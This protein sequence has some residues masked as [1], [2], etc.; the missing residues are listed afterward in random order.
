MP[1]DKALR[2]EWVN[3][4]YKSGMGSVQV[5]PPP[6]KDF[7]RV[8]H[9]TSAEFAISDIGL[10]R[11]KVARF[12]DVND[13]FELMALTFMERRMRNIARKFKHTYDSHTG[14]LCFSADW[15]NPVLWS[16]YG[17]KHR[18]ICLGFNLARSRAEKVQYEDNIILPKLG[19]GGTTESLDE[20]QQRLLLH[21]KFRHWEYEEEIRSF[22]ELETMV[23]EGELYFCPF[24][25]NLQLTEVILGPEC[26]LSLDGV[27]Q[28]TRALHPRAV[29]FGA[30]LAINSFKVVPK[31]STVL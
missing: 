11:M 12:S 3:A 19:R 17:A 14:L 23:R 22:L 16:H 26:R 1:M 27:R 4:G 2:S 28:L 9:L 18:G 24:D 20:K 29:A 30:R 15:T 25:D 13:P 6:P 10:S 31:E 21:T 5:V 8:Y 7:I